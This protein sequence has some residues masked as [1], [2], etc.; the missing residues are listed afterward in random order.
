MTGSEYWL[1]EFHLDGRRLHIVWH[2]N[3]K[4]GLVRLASGK[5]ASF[6][7]EGAVHAF[8]RSSG[9][10]LMPNRLG[11]Y[12]F[13][14]IETWCHRPTAES[15]DPVAFLNIWNM[16]E[17]ALG[18]KLTVKAVP[19]LSEISLGKVRKIYDKLFFG[20][21]LPTMTPPGKSYEPIWAQDEVE[22]MSRLYR[23]GLTELR[24]NIY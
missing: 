22:I 11:G 14:A 10:S 13:D 15:V 3:D 24:S 6:G 16:L 5:I 2:T 17:D 9:I 4:D 8:C 20:N 1:C 21:N 12:D 19:N 7:D 23:F 18:F